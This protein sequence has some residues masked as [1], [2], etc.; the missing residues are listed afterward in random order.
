MGGVGLD[1]AA[2]AHDP[3]VDRPVEGLR[4]AGIGQFQQP[5]ARENPLGIGGEDLQQTVFRGRERMLV[6]LVV[7]QRLGVVV[8]PFGAESHPGAVGRGRRGGR[9]R[10]RCRRRLTGAAPAQ[11]RADAGQKLA[12]LAGLGEIVVRPELEADHAIDRA[13]G[14]GEHDDR[15][16]HALLEVADDRKPVLLRHVEIE[17]DQVRHLLRDGLAQA[18]A[19]VA[20]AHVEP[21]HAKIV[22]DHL[23][24][25]LLVVDYHDVLSLG[26]VTGNVILKAAPC[27]GPA[28]STVTRPPC[29]STMRL[30]IERPRPV[31]VSP[32]VGFAESRWKRPN[33]REMSSG[34][35]PAPWSLTWTSILSPS[36]ATKSSMA[37]PIGLYLIALLTRLSMA[38]RMRSESHMAA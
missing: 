14:R 17:D 7:A 32:A 29:R 22:A 8:E 35:R 37:P 36:R 5:V 10:G 34:D 3:Q 28:L 27:P 12:Q 9:R 25:G 1:L 2:D 23:A 11:H 13:R 15:H 26:H 21:V 6:A 16:A 4:V 20:Q 18:G 31:E 24:R 19:A 30:T 33:S 38:S